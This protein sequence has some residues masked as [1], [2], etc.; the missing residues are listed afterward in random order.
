MYIYVQKKSSFDKLWATRLNLNNR[1]AGCKTKVGADC[2]VEL[3]NT[4]L[5]VHH[6]E[7]FTVLFICYRWSLL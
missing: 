3:G 5:W 6:Y 4:Y 7:E 1:D 2:K